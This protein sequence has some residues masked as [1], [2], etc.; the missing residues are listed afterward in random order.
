MMTSPFVGGKDWDVRSAI[1]SEI[2]PTA[3]HGQPSVGETGSVVL[4]G[5]G[6]SAPRSPGHKGQPGDGPP[7]TTRVG[8]GLA[9]AHFRFPKCACPFPRIWPI[10]KLL[11]YGLSVMA[12][13]S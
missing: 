3:L 10:P 6:R 2:A 9:S 8:P 11:H 7:P 4:R 5:A 12:I 1:L 13:P